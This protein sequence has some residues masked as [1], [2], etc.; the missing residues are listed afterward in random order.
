LNANQVEPFFDAAAATEASAEVRVV[1][2]DPAV[3]HGNFDTASRQSQRALRDIDSRHRERRDQI[4]HGTGLSFDLLQI[5]LG[6][7]ID[8]QD[9][10]Q[11]P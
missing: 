4:G 5:D 9:A 7:G 10:G 11:L 3:D 6:D 2:V 1:V 8:G